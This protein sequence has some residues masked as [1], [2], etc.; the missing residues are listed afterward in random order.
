MTWI[1]EDT[2]ETMLFGRGSVATVYDLN[3][4]LPH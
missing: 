1:Y 3:T 2:S 4:T